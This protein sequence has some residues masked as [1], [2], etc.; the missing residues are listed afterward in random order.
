MKACL[1][2]RVPILINRQGIKE[3]EESERGG[4]IILNISVKGGRWIEG[5]LLLEEIRL[6][7][8]TF[9]DDCEHGER[10]NTTIWVTQR[11]FQEKVTF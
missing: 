2:T 7:I 8:Y 4:A 6:P 11:C 3:R 1:L 10:R 5:R 9:G